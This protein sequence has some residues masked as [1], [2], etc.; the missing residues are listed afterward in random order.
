MNGL[1]RSTVNFTVNTA[2]RF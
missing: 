2:E 1:N